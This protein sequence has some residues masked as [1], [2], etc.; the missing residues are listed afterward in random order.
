[1]QRLLTRLFKPGCSRP[2]ISYFTEIVAAIY[3]AIRLKWSKRQ[4][5]GWATQK[6]KKVKIQFP[7]TTLE[8]LRWVNVPCA[9]AID[10]L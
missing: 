9:I 5:A 8:F 7:S 10:T 1:M 4:K 2:G 6:E 3:S